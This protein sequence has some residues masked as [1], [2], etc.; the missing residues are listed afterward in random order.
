MILILIVLIKP[1]DFNKFCLRENKYTC[2]EGETYSNFKLGQSDVQRE[3][4]IHVAHLKSVFTIY[5][6]SPFGD[7][8]IESNQ[9][10]DSNR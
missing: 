3:S 2:I 1:I 5:V 4:Y 9:N 10:P 6:C 8:D 7:S